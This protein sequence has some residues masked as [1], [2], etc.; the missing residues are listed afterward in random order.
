M[1]PDRACELVQKAQCP[2]TALAVS[3]E[4]P[5]AIFLPCPQFGHFGHLLTGRRMLAPCCDAHPRLDNLVCCYG[6]LVTEDT[7]KLIEVLQWD[8]DLVLNTHQLPGMIRLPEVWVPLPS[9]VKGDY[10]DRRQ[11]RSVR[12]C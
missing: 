8:P 3:T 1:S 9:L 12:R 2:E 5:K 4:L 11:C 7:K 10:V 6:R